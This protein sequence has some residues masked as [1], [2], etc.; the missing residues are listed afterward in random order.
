MSEKS[1]SESTGS[2][3]LRRAASIV[4]A[5][6]M[7]PNGATLT[8]I[9]EIVG[10]PSSTVH[11][12][13]TSLVGIDYL[14]IDRTRRVY[15]L[16]SRVR[17]LLHFTLDAPTLEAVLT[18]SLR[19]LV[20][21]IKEIA[22]VARLV[23]QRIELVH[24]VLPEPADRS[25]VYPGHEFPLHATATGKAIFAFQPS[26][27]IQKALQQKAE[28]YQATTMTRKEDILKALKDVRKRGHAVHDSEYDADVYAVA[29]PIE[30]EGIGV[31]YSVG[32]VGLKE[33]M[34]REH[35]LDEVIVRLKETAKAL[36]RV[37]NAHQKLAARPQKR[38]GR[39][40]KAA[41]R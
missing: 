17:R 38:A 15:R 6:A 3:P 40:T 18:P 29:C 8:E 22:F 21:D 23:G 5:V 13:S 33:R 30:I 9:A 14:E 34:Q 36:S 12:V 24:S 11:R 7:F 25:L 2:A 20:Q 26:E 41:G 28:K 19:E 32:I 4:D 1:I 16:G 35:S 31:M 37:L 10:L 39:P 27:V